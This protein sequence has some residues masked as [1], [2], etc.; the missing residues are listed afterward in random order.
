MPSNTAW[1]DD[2]QS[3]SQSHN[4]AS[5]RYDPM[6][7]RNGFPCEGRWG[8]SIIK[9]QDLGLSEHIEL[10]ACSDISSKDRKNL[11][12]GVHH[13]VDDYRFES[14]YRN[15]ERSLEKYAKYQFVLTPDYSLFPEMPLW[16]QI[17]SIGKSRWVGAFWQ[18]HG[19]SVVPTVGWGLSPTL[20]FCFAAIE[21]RC[22]VAVG[23]IGCKHGRRS[24]MRGYDAMLERIDPSL[25][26]CLGKPF[27]QMRGNLVVVDYAASRR[28]ER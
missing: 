23:M 14:L 25:I 21:R 20:E 17:E 26:V 16:R 18:H 5:Y 15:P 2:G 11:R 6:F 22:A 19:L 3:N 7:L 27:A 10:I 9:K 4:K 24:F 12:K 13:F 8:F 28:T 1:C